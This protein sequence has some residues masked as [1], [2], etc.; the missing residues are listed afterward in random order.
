[1][2]RINMIHP[3]LQLDHP[4]LKRAATFQEV[5]DFLNVEIHFVKRVVKAGK[6]RVFRPKPNV[7]RSL[8]YDLLA[9]LEAN[10]RPSDGRPCDIPAMATLL[11]ASAAPEASAAS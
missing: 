1:M 11:R 5:A 10:S 3:A 4:A 2:V 9:Y 6:I 8:P 7:A